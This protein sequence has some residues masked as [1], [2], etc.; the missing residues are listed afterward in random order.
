MFEW[1]L[2]P[3]NYSEKATITIWQRNE[4]A[5]ALFLV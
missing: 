2:T 1:S 4:T 5:K 3:N